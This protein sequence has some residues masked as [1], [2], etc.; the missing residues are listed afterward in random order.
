MNKI[1]T[2]LAQGSET[3][4]PHNVTA[5]IIVVLPTY[6]TVPINTPTVLPKGG[7]IPTNSPTYM[8]QLLF[9]K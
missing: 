6:S 8:L 5:R 9:Y 7:T 1:E 4:S 2:P 3:I